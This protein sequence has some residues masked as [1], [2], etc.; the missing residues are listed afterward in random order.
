MTENQNITKLN[1]MNLFA[2]ARGYEILHSTQQSSELS[3]EGLVKHLVESEWDD[4]HGKKSTIITS[5]PPVTKWHDVIA[6]Q[7]I[8]D[9]ILDRL[10]YNAHKDKEMKAARGKIKVVL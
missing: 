7:T 4:R 8:A 9:A 5:Q 3:D 1:Q 10:F 2:I 6:D